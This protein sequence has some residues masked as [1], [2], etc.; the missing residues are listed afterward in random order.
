MLWRVLPVS[1]VCWLFSSLRGRKSEAYRLIM[2]SR[3]DGQRLVLPRKAHTRRN[4][5]TPTQTWTHACFPF[6]QPSLLK[7]FGGRTLFKFV[8]MQKHILYHHLKDLILWK[9]ITKAIRGT[10]DKKQTNLQL[11]LSNS[12]QQ[13]LILKLFNWI[14]CCYYCRF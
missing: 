5:R 7:G 1:L 8:L 13:V 2:L 11:L 3:H 6:P 14:F 12:S 9:D 10:K 4:T